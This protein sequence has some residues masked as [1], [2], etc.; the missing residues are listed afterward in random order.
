MSQKTW[1]QKIEIIKD[2]FSKAPFLIQEP[3]MPLKLKVIR[4]AKIYP[5]DYVPKTI[6]EEVEWLVTQWYTTLGQPIPAEEVGI[7]YTID[8][9]ERAKW[10]NEFKL[11]KETPKEVFEEDI[12]PEFGTPAFWAW[13]R[14]QKIKKDAERAEQGLPPLPTKKEAEAAK[15]IKAKEREVAKAVKVSEAAKKL[16]EK[17]AKIS[18]K[19]VRQASKN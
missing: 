11:L 2:A 7:G 6:G 12:K 1:L 14:K 15:A 9:I 19:K 8:A 4:P 18:E 10:D 3:K 16:A 17:E 5:E 13:A